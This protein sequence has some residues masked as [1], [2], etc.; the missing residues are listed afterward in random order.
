VSRKIPK[1]QNLNS[2]LLEGYAVDLVGDTFVLLSSRIADKKL[3]QEVTAVR[4]M[5]QNEELLAGVQTQYKEKRGVRV[6]GRIAA[7]TARFG[8]TLA[9]IPEHI[10]WRP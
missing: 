2:I 4:I 8:D 3:G 5:I 10:E 9:I 6:V 1:V 7:I